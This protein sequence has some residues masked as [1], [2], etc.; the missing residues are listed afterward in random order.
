ME[1]VFGAVEVE[2]QWMGDAACHYE[3]R[4]GDS[5]IVIE[6][7]EHAPEIVETVASVYV[8]VEDVDVTWK[9]AMEAG[10]T[11]VAEPEDKPYQERGA[12]FQ[13]AHGN[14]WYVST[15]TG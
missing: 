15:Y 8:Y 13:D 5:T 1:K 9:R 4:I 2:C 11:P 3:A 12:G 6:A 10:A 14:T 7:G